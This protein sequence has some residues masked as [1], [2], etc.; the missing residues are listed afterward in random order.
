MVGGIALGIYYIQTLVNESKQIEIQNVQRIEERFITAVDLLG[1]EESSARVGAMYSLYHLAIEKEGEKYSVAIAEIL[2]SHIRTKTQEKG[3]QEDYKDSSSEEIQTTIDLLFRKYT[4][5]ERKDMYTLLKDDL[6][7]ADLSQSYLKGA[8]LHS[9]QLQGADLRFAQLQGAKFLSAQLQGAKF[10]AAQ[11]QGAKFLSAQLQGADLFYAQLQGASLGGA[12]FQGADLRGA[13]F[14][15]ASL[16]YAQFQGASLGGAQFQEATFQNT[17]F[18]GAYSNNYD[19]NKTRAENL[20]ARIRIK[21]E[22][23]LSEVVFSGE[24]NSDAIEAIENAKEYLSE[25][26]YNRMKKIIQENKG[27]NVEYGKPTEEQKKGIETG[28]L[29]D[30]EEIRA[31]IKELKAIEIEKKNKQ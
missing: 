22:T 16:R 23:D 5:G 20:E 30:S 13:Q 7:A 8:G 26:W 27:V 12:Q 1:S 2:C 24:I 29:E 17:N 4:L 3:Y 6:P 10:M 11:L 31:I 28:V 25:K 15:G 14:Q 9:A 18:K 19:N 21:Q